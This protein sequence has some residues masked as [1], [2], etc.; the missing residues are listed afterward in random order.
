MCHSIPSNALR[1]AIPPINMRPCGKVLA[2][3][4]LDLNYCPHPGEHMADFEKGMAS[5][6]K[7]H[8]NFCTT[9]P[10]SSLPLLLLLCPSWKNKQ[11]ICTLRIPPTPTKQPRRRRALNLSHHWVH[12]SS[13]IE[14]LC[15]LQRKMPNTFPQSRPR[16]T[17]NTD[18][19]WLTHIPHTAPRATG[20]Q[21]PCCFYKRMEKFRGLRG[22]LIYQTS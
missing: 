16:F 21:F 18:E 2:A 14:I 1:C 5:S 22:F 20:R 11:R 10:I 19:P 6:D 17:M 8:K 3:V 13:I 15:P 9:E 4:L 12:R 7:S